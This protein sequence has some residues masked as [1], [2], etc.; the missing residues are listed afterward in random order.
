MQQGLIDQAERAYRLALQSEQRRV[1][2]SAAKILGFC[3]FGAATINRAGTGMASALK[4]KA[5]KPTSGVVIPSTVKF[6]PFG[7]T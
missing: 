6:S 7:M 1:R 2:R 5:W 3:C 4:G